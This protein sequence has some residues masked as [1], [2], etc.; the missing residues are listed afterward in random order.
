MKVA[1]FG[2][3]GTI[4][5]A[6][7]AR[8]AGDHEVTGV[9][10]RPRG[11][12]GGVRWAVADAANPTAVHSVLDGIEVVYYL[13]HS[14]GT[15]DFAERDRR[16]ATIMARAAESAGVRQIVYLGGLGGDGAE[17]SEHLRS[18]RE[19]Q[20]ALGAGRV[21]VT[22][23][24]AAVVIGRG[25]AAFETIVALVDRLPAMVCPRWVSTPTQP[26][27]LADAVSYLAAV[28][29]MESASAR[30]TGGGPE[31][32]TYRDMIEE[33]AALRGRHPRIVEVPLLTPR[34]SSYWLQLV[35]PV[36]GD[37]ARPLIEGLR[38]P[39]VA[40]DP[41]LR[42]LLPFALTTLRQAAQQAMAQTLGLRRP[43]AVK[44]PKVGIEPTRPCGHGILSPARLPVP[45][46]R[47]AAANDTVRRLAPLRPMLH[48]VVSPAMGG[49]RI[50]LLLATVVCLLLAGA[51][52]AGAAAGGWRTSLVPGGDHLTSFE[53][54]AAVPGG[55]VWA[56]G[57]QGGGAAYDT[58]MAWR[59]DASGWQAYTIPVDLTGRWGYLTA[60]DGSSADD[61]WAVGH[62]TI[63]ANGSPQPLVAHWDGTAWRVVSQPFIPPDQIALLDTVVASSPM[64]VWVGGIANNG[65][66]QPLLWH[67]TG[68]F[69][70]Q[71][72]VPVRNR[73]CSG[74][75]AW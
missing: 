53:G 15:P 10:R 59:H 60:I 42:E 34:L 50:A 45:P 58:P 7:I 20:Q 55:Q 25:S 4:G 6:L 8:L 32:M 24:G 21:P 38:N 75:S 12:E 36:K 18:R 3:S 5:T 41:R 19:T 13:V 73:A 72:T 66:S 30:P 70:T 31:V 69:W 46:L 52:S 57:G 16:A 63:Q 40:H 74:G 35:T 49:R 61:V 27:A 56:V 9:S 11:D 23:I 2:A 44:V 28:C 68:F 65:V 48:L 54:L 14:L 17:L 51:G 29:G 22:A 64:D 1:V 47:L 71:V 33:I 39:T 37:V 67:F 62:T 26:I 43:D